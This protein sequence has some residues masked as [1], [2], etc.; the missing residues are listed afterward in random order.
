MSM[1]HLL[2][3][4]LQTVRINQLKLMKQRSMVCI[5]ETVVIVNVRFLKNSFFASFILISD[6]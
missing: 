5:Y 1:S 4:I 3:A 6:I 2:N